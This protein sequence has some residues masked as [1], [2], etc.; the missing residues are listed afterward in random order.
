MNAHDIDYKLYGDDMQFVEIELDPQESV[1]AEAGGMM[2][3]E[4]G[5]TMETIFGDGSDSR[6][7][8]FNKL[9]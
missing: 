1:I 8:F 2:M 6:K 4:D 5:I 7:G 3:M 9:L